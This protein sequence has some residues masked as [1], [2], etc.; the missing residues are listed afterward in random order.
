MKT[1]IVKRVEEARR[2]WKRCS[3]VLCDKRMP[4]KQ[5]GKV[6]RTVVRPA[7]CYMERK[8]GSPPNNRMEGS[9][10]MRCGC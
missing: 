7:R 10:L 6:Y 8:H 1:E 2:K 4:V 3:G 9:R 5:K